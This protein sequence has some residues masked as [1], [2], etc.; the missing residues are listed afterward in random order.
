MA[1]TPPFDRIPRPRRTPSLSD[2][3]RRHVESSGQHGPARRVA[4]PDSYSEV[5]KKLALV[6]VMG[7][8]WWEGLSRTRIFATG[9]S[10]APRLEALA[11]P[12][13]ATRVWRRR[14]LHALLWRQPRWL[15][16]GSSFTRGRRESAATGC[17]CT[18][19]S[20]ERSR[21]DTGCSRS[22]ARAG[23]RLVCAGEVGPPGVPIE[24]GRNGSSPA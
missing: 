20:R 7:N 4:R 16:G 10:Q 1:A 3:K 14:T 12:R 5:L 2:S 11:Q 6:C 18:R 17:S 24:A 22:S 8:L 9:S 19:R 15:F 21:G 13:T 23:Q